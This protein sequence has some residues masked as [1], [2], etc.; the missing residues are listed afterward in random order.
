MQ[1]LIECLWI[2]ILN[3]KINKMLIWRAQAKFLLLRTQRLKEIVQTIKR[4][5]YIYIIYICFT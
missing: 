2:Y 5:I 1:I 4:R 3:S